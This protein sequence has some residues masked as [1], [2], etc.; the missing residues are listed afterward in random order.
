MVTRIRHA[1]EGI[2]DYLI[3]G[4]GKA[5][6]R[7]YWDERYVLEGDI[8]VTDEIIKIVERKYKYLH[9]TASFIEDDISIDILNSITQEFKEFYGAGYKKG[10]L[11]FYSEAHLPK[12]KSVTDKV[13]GITKTRKKH[14]HLIIPTMN[15]RTGQSTNPVG[16]HQQH[17]VYFEAF[18]KMIAAKYGLQEVSLKNKTTM[19]SEVINSF[20]RTTEKL[21]GQTRQVD[22]KQKLLDT[23]I[24][25][26]MNYESLKSYLNS[27][28]FEG[29]KIRNK[30]KSNEYLWVKPYNEKGINLNDTYFY[31]RYMNSNLQKKKAK[32]TIENNLECKSLREPYLDELDKKYLDLIE[33]W[34]SDRSRYVKLCTKPSDVKKY[35]IFNAIKKDAKKSL[36]SLLLKQTKQLQD[37]NLGE[38]TL[39]IIKREIQQAQQNLIDT[40]YDLNSF[41][42]DLEKTQDLRALKNFSYTNNIAQ[43]EYIHADYK[44]EIIP[45]K[46]LATK[47]IN[48]SLYTQNPLITNTVSTIINELNNSL[49]QN[50]LQESPQDTMLTSFKET[51]PNYSK[52]KKPFILSRDF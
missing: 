37:K 19:Q 49:A 47:D 36:K 21:K 15:I 45:S 24:Q 52:L 31:N 41:F 50:Q 10:D 51:N 39:N 46:K 12:I 11:N 26:D 34:K 16:L 17:L 44:S 20:I 35:K 14:F 9:I 18:N 30:G 42:D 4:T 29:F 23:I 28:K 2:V 48:Y 22:F 38:N 32:L 13:T 1:K 33:E 43:E 25:E 8:E 40:T 3:K 27:D 6:G 5:L 7:D